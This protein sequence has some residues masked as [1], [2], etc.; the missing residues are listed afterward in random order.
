[1]K[2]TDI[3]V[4]R[5]MNENNMLENAGHIVAGV[6]GGADSMYLLYILMK[7]A[8]PENIT[9]V[10]VNHCLRG[11]DAD[12]DQKYVEEWCGVHGVRCRVFRKDIKKYAEEEHITEEEAGRNYRYHVFQTEASK[13]EKSV[14]AVAHHMD[15]QAETV[16]FHL[17]RGSALNGL[18]GMKP[19][20]RD[21]SLVRPLLCVRKAEIT[22]RLRGLGISWRT[23]ATN[24]DTRY[25]RNFIRN[26]VIPFLTENVQKKSVEHISSAASSVREVQD[27]LESA[28]EKSFCENVQSTENGLFFNAGNVDML[29]PA[30]EKELVFLCMK[31]VCGKARDITENHILSVVDII[32][33]GTGRSVMLPYGMKAFKEYD[34]VIISKSTENRKQSAFKVR[35][36]SHS[37]EEDS[38]ICDIP[39]AAPNEISSE[40]SKETRNETA[41]ETLNENSNEIS[42]VFSCE[43]PDSLDIYVSDIPDSINEDRSI[44]ESENK[45]QTEN[46]NL[47]ESEVHNKNK[48]QLQ[49]HHGN[50]RKNVAVSNPSGEKTEFSMRICHEFPGA[51]AVKKNCTAFID[52]DT[53]SGVLTLRASAAG[54]TLTLADGR[55]KKLSRIFIDEKIPRDKRENILVLAEGNHVIWVPAL[56]RIGREHYVTGNSKNILEITAEKRA[57]PDQKV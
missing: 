33:G 16:L 41:G 26:E 32:K 25:S 57:D 10:H 50:K 13:H 56:G 19:V 43:L 44:N 8:G 28:A 7:A 12:A 53:I 24:S 47:N 2:E 42:D 3:R 9:A 23:D 55:H 11:K 21:G 34:N 27:F 4:F 48:E 35:G 36:V 49:Y 40:I 37:A 1:M 52:C 20:S 39:W 38:A 17:L 5:F 30:V 18:G 51:D 29:H 15:D 6:S 54:D 45:N 14:I 22:E 31:K 46:K